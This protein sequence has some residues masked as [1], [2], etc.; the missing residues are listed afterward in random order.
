MQEHQ[1]PYLS[2]GHAVFQNTSNS[3]VTDV[4]TISNATT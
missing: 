2:P 3:L 4:S 1:T